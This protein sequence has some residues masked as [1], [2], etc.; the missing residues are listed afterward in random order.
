MLRTAASGKGG[1]YA[2][3]ATNGVMYAALV[4]RIPALGA[5]LGLST[6]ELGLLLLWLSAGAVSGLPVAGILVQR[7]GGSRGISCGISLAAVGTVGLAVGIEIASGLAA[8]VALYLIGLGMGVWEISMNVVGSQIAQLIESESLLP[9]FHAALSLGTVVGA[10]LGATLAKLSVP[11]PSQNVG[12]VVLLVVAGFVI[13]RV[14]RGTD[15]PKSRQAG[16][17]PARVLSDSWRE[18]RT[19]LIGIC[20]LG[21]AFTEGTANEWLAYVLVD[22]YGATEQTGAIAFAAFVTAMTV[23]RVFGGILVARFGR[24]NVLR[25]SAGLALCGL[26]VVVLND[27]VSWALVGALMW[28]LGAAMGFP[29][30]IAAAGDDPARAAARVAV[31]SSLGYAAFLGGPPLLGL[32][33]GLFGIQQ[34]ILVVSAAL[35]LAFLAAGSTQRIRPSNQTDGT[36]E[37]SRL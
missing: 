11:L 9:R 37:A 26:L 25:V 20:V 7:L 14:T 34:A 5:E 29:V 31:V 15:A 2:A 22:G 27:D 17:A 18:R 1:V 23:G 16:R 3:F 24:G 35:L 10:I 33:G 28:G 6:P 36:P 32:L 19:L 13:R 4:S 8:A 30:C 12:I 21:F